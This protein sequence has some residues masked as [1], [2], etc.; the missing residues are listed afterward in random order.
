MIQSFRHDGLRE[1]WETGKSKKVNAQWIK[2]IMPRL[3][4]LNNAGSVEDVDLPGYRL[5]PLKG[6]RAGVWAINVTGNW[7][8]TFRPE[9]EEDDFLVH[10]VDLE[11]YHSGKKAMGKTEQTIE[12]LKKRK[13]RPMGPG[14]LAASLLDENDVTNSEAAS[15]LGISRVHL[16][17]FLNGHVNL[18]PDM[19]NRLALFFGNSAA[20]WMRVQHDQEMWDL[21]H[22][23]QKAYSDVVPLDKA[24]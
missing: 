18:T 1:V 21:V 11:D 20:F 22:T 13:V 23:D 5:H 9:G 8:M 17:R 10:D 15:K 19:A 6:E 14:A 16:N 3:V 4:V 7:R 12:S 24:A 2:R